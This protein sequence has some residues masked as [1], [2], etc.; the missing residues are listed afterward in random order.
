MDLLETG[1][2]ILEE[3]RQNRTPIYSPLLLSSWP[4]HIPISVVV[5]CDKLWGH[6]YPDYSEWVLPFE[7][8]SCLG[9]STVITYNRFINSLG[10]WISLP[11]TKW[12]LIIA[13]WMWFISSRFGKEQTVFKV[14]TMARTEAVVGGSLL[15]GEQMENL[16]LKKAN[17]LSLEI[18]DCLFFLLSLVWKKNETV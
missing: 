14:F 12:K 10:M 2:C 8:I 7:V 5:L 15:F 6:M 17:H 13:I 1:V 11:Q 18:T 3:W 9:I 16:R 4:A